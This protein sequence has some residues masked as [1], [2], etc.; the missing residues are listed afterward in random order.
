[1]LQLIEAKVCMLKIKES[2]GTCAKIFK[3]IVVL[4]R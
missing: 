4:R 3:K 2:R 1:M